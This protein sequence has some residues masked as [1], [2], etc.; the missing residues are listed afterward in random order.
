M[1]RLPSVNDKLQAVLAGAVATTQPICT[2]CYSDQTTS[3]YS[4]GKQIAT[5]NGATDVDILSAPAAF[6]VRDVDYLSVCNLDTA[7]IALT[8]KYDISGVDST[9]VKVTLATLETIQYIHGSGWSCLDASGN[10]KTSASGSPI[11]ADNLF[12]V[13]DN[14]DPSK[15]FQFQASGITTGTLRTYTTPNSSGTLALLEFAQTWTAAQTF[16]AVTTVSNTTESTSSTTGAFVVAGSIGIGGNESNFGISNVNATTFSVHNASAA[17][18]SPR[19]V[20]AQ[21]GAT[22]FGI[23][24][25]VSS[26]IIEGQSDGG[27]VLGAFSGNLK[28]TGNSR[29]VLGIVE[30]T[31]GNIIW[32]KDIKLNVA[33]NGFYVKEGTNATMGVATL[34]AGTVTVNTTKV[35]ANSRIFLTGQSDG[36]TVGFQRV[37]ARTAGTSFTITSSSGSDTSTVAWVLLE[38]A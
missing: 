6:T 30:G 1:I 21:G 2:V 15:Q 18:G 20:I 13:Q 11:F 4:G 5:L 10:V 3:G 27:M 17:G 35:T 9:I 31:T 34:V 28:F 7:S 16:S 36:G 22:A 12:T 19:M 14:A 38:P 26:G 32:D 23:A 37:S 24:P 25:W 8:I 29:T 33:G